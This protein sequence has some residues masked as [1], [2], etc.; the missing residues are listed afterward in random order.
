MQDLLGPDGLGDRMHLRGRRRR[1]GREQIDP[2]GAEA[3]ARIRE[4]LDPAVSV[5]RRDASGRGATV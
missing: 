2:N 5:D 3:A 1:T 4:Q